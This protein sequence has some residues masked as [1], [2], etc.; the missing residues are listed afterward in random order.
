M[1]SAFSNI[2]R[3]SQFRL[4]R[5]RRLAP[6]WLCQ[7]FDSFAFE[8]LRLAM[9]LTLGAEMAALESATTRAVVFASFVI[10]ALIGAPLGG[11][12]AD[13]FDRHIVLRLIQALL[14]VTAITGAWALTNNSRPVVLIA[15]A[16]SGFLAALFS[17]A[18]NAVVRQ[19]LE[20]G[21]LVAGLGL[22][23]A[24]R[25]LSLLTG[26]LFAVAAAGAPEWAMGLIPWVL[27]LAGLSSVAAAFWVPD[28]PVA[29]TEFRIAWSPVTA[30]RN[31]L[32]IVLRDRNLF[33]AVLGVSWFW[34]AVLVYLVYLPE[35]ANQVLSIPKQ[36]TP[37][38]L[39][40]PLFGTL[41][42]ALAC[43]PASGRRIEPGLVPLGSIGMAVAG[44]IF[45]ASAP[46]VSVN[47]GSTLTEWLR[48]PAFRRTMLGLFLF[49]ASAALFVTPLR[50]MILSLAPEDKVGRVVGGMLL[51]NL[52][53]VSG[54]LIVVDWL[55]GEGLSVEALA[56][57]VTLM[58]AGVSIYIF[59][60]LP[61]F[62]LR[63]VM[64]LLV[65]LVYRVD[66]SGLEHVPE[67]GPAVIVCNHITYMDA[68]VIG[69][70]VRRPV[71]FVMHKFIFE[72]PVLGTVFRLAK[73]IPIVSAKKNPEALAAAM[74]QVARE[75]EAGRLVGIF[76][77]GHLT[78]DGDMHQFREGIERIVERTSVPVVPM[79]LQGLWGSFFSNCGGAPMA[80][81]P[82]FGWSR[83]GLRVGPPI[84]A[85]E[86]SAGDL[87]R[88]VAEL[89]GD[90]A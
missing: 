18:R 33:L 5:D 90:Q 15:L 64:W 26:T 35:F 34:L 79:A 36:H 37:G 27:A 41:V 62:L 55:R 61:E 43:Y 80:H 20:E 66:V 19:Q 8:S 22:L 58:H 60:L 52:I 70:R 3:A 87:Q 2:P 30:I 89:R 71:R 72:I 57:T 23:T 17:A 84:A 29:K 65:H 39:I 54:A 25:H 21:E 45:Y 51:Y 7:L 81:R 78:P 86:V 88:R 14:L 48:E 42:G 50:A 68:L 82:R 49:G 24:A 32:M 13:R 12:L 73:A 75:L 38:V 77:E 47:A 67:K 11:Q 44:V 4:L 85:E 56:L 69:A 9:L 59:L 1:R 31:T 83:I 10:P 53:F 40:A 76:P 74:D 6:L 46:D 28:S 16:M 63:L